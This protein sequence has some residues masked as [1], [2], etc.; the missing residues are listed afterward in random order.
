MTLLATEP[1]ASIYQLIDLHYI[2][3]SNK[4]NILYFFL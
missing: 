2:Y 4:S 3:I 1:H